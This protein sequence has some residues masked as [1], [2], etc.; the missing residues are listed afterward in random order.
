M[1]D[2]TAGPLVMEINRIK[3]NK[4][5]RTIYTHIEIYAGPNVVEAHQMIRDDRHSDFENNYRDQRTITLALSL[6]DAVELIGPYQD[7]LKIMLTTYTDSDEDEKVST[8]YRAYLRDDIP[9]NMISAT[10]PVLDNRETSNRAGIINLSFAI[11]LIVVEYLDNI[12]IGTV[13]RPAPPFS[14]LKTMMKVYLDA[15]NLTED[16]RIKSISMY[17]ASNFESRIQ[18]PIPQNTR[19]VDLPD[20]LQNTYG[21]IYSTGLGFYLHNRELHFW[22][23]YDLVR[24][25][26]NQKYLHVILGGSVHSSLIDKTYLVEGNVIS[27]IG[28]A[29]ISILDDTLG[30]VNNEGDSVRYMDGRKVLNNSGSAVNNVFSSERA[31]VNTELTAAKTRQSISII[32]QSKSRI[33]S[34]IYFELSKI[35]KRGVVRVSITWRFSNPDLII[36]GMLVKLFYHRD[37]EV[38]ETQGSVASISSLTSTTKEGMISKDMGT[39]SVLVIMIDRYDPILEDFIDSG[40]EPISHTVN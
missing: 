17:E 5:H 31:T 6:G 30:A 27:I 40:N 1:V 8:M 36:P 11:N 13:I 37:D 29:P 15:V 16:D 34:N 39:N 18:T 7:D 24:E 32:R 22:P 26:Y 10:Q 9:R 33:T 23:T 2:I 14:I 28:V 21:G 19:L 3:N 4:L 12:S 38:R 35:A 25:K 20:L